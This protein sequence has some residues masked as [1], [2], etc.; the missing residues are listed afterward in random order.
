VRDWTEWVRQRLC[1]LGVGAERE[2]EITRELAHHFEDISEE[3]QASGRSPKDAHDQ[4]S[5]EVQD[6]ARF[7]KSIRRAEREGGFMK[8]RMK[9]LWLPA[10]GTA[11]LAIAVLR[12]VI[13][14]SPHAAGVIWVG[15]VPMHFYAGW[16]ELL[17]LVGA[18]GAFASWYARGT[19][20]EIFLTAISLPVVMGALFAVA[21]PIVLVY[22]QMPPQMMF[23]P[24]LI[25]VLGWVILP[26]LALLIG[27]APFIFIRRSPAPVT[28]P[29]N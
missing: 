5:S 24:A 27:A 25:A 26:G 23:L 19:K 2:D 17:P 1:T 20:S 10:F 28:T 6:W 4:A 29:A 9:S 14:R 3:A 16:L 7:T 18:L 15:R 11:W 8:Q 13:A 22:K 21:F 12:W